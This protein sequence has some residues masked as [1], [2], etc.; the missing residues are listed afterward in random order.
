MS[1]PL[2]FTQAAIERAIRAVEKR[3]YKV[4]GVR[5]DGTVLEIRTAYAA[6]G[7]HVR[8]FTDITE[9]R[10]S[11]AA[12]ASPG[13]SRSAASSAARDGWERSTPTT[14]RR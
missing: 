13:S 7:S 10:R 4:G 6:D 2:P 9:A 3:G 8:T 1:K 12:I 11:A 14:I 5:P